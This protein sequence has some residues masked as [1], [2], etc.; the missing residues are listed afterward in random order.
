MY[1]KLFSEWNSG[2]MGTF[3]GI[4]AFYCHIE[5]HFTRN[6]A[7]VRLSIKAL[8]VLF[9]PATYCTKIVENRCYSVTRCVHICAQNVNF[10]LIINA[11]FYKCLPNLTAQVGLDLICQ[12]H[13]KFKLSWK[14]DKVNIRT[15]CYNDFFVLSH[16]AEIWPKTSNWAKKWELRK[17]RSDDIFWKMMTIGDF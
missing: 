13:Q 15:F 2:I 7:S 4:L 5:F 10:Y 11:D 6:S 16:R 17:L 9:S 3:R 1:Y 12:D 8:S 14:L